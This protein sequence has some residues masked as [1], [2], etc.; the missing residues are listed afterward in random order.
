MQILTALKNTPLPIVLIAAGLYFLVFSLGPLIRGG[1]QDPGKRQNASIATGLILLLLGI[2]LYLLPALAG[3]LFRTDPPVI[4]G[5]IIRENHEGSELVYQ[6]EVNFYDED[7]NTNLLEREL[8]D[9]SDPS[10]GEY[11]DVEN[12]SI[13]AQPAIQKIRSTA[14]DTWHCGGHIYVA[15]VQV[16]LVDQDGN[17]SEPVRY[18]IECK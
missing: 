14:T 4:L 12:V 18:R 13:E 9:I 17:R 2:S 1:I 5:V 16:T 10:Q 15:T 6:Q 3:A 8:I 11:I 7:G